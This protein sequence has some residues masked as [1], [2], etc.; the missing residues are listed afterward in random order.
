MTQQRVSAEDMKDR[1]VRFKDIEGK[2]S[3]VGVP[4]MFIDSILPGHYRMN[5]AVIGDTASE[6]PEFRPLLD[7]PHKFQV[8]MFMA[9]PGNG[10]AWHT[11]DYVEI[12]MPLSGKWRFYWGTDAD[13]PDEPD[14]E[15]ILGP[16]DVISFPAGLWRGFENAGEEDAWGF[17]VLES[18]EVFV[19]QD[20]I[21]PGWLIE[22][23]RQHGLQVD[24]YGKMIKPDDFGK[25]REKAETELLRR[26]TDY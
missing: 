18:H 23:A 2:G 16:R 24:D 21:W 10:P 8:G 3:P 5:Y 14:G 7:Q 13:K 12:F 17:A 15:E 22:E 4:L 19:D 1:I 25:L 26:S 20:P 11:H 9:P 6:D